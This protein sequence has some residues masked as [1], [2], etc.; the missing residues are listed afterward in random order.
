LNRI[1]QSL[2]IGRKLSAIIISSFYSTCSG[3][4]KVTIPVFKQLQESLGERVG[5]DVRLVSITVDP[6]NDNPEVLRQYAAG[7]T[8]FSD[9]L[10]IAF[11]VDCGGAYKGGVRA[12]CLKNNRGRASHSIA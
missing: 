12:A 11:A 4:C 10:Q 6:E 2:W 8:I 5:K 9:R 7:R 1:V 3:V